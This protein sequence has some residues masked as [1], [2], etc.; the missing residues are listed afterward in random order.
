MLAHVPFDA[1]ITV[2]GDAGLLRERAGAA[3]LAVKDFDRN[4]TEPHRGD[5]CLTVLP[6]PVA[7]P[8]TAGAINPANSPYVMRLLD[9]ALGG[10]RSGEWHALVTCPVHK[11]AINRAG[12]PFSGHT[13][14]LAQKC[15]ADAV[16]LLEN[17]A[18]KVALATTHL[19][20]KAVPGAITQSGLER[21]L[22]IVHHDLIARFGIAA[23]RIGVCGLNPH[24]GEQ[25]CLGDEEQQCISPVIQRLQREQFDVTGPL[26]ADTAFTA[27]R[28]KQY[29]VILA[30]FHDQG[31]PVIKHAGFGA[32]V[33][34]TLGLPFVRTSVDHGTALDLAGGGK[35]SCAS[36]VAAVRRAVDLC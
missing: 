15:A 25:G 27:D 3:A 35:A 16:M 18:M 33:N 14:Y 32:T 20:L 4:K 12:I 19:P 22:R 2:L 5:G 1:A 34:I 26:P 13:E 9:R 24:A 11:A 17:D 31:L 36:L 23:P 29:D 10:C 6:V 28:L 30:M 8:V 7:E 21:M